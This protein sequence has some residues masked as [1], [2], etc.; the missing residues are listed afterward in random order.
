MSLSVP[1]ML[2]ARVSSVVE[3]KNSETQT[4]FLGQ[5]REKNVHVGFVQ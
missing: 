1:H 4:L 5:L 3:H 2:L